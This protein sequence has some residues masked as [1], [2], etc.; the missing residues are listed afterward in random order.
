M[1]DPRQDIPLQ[2]AKLLPLALTADYAQLAIE[3]AKLVAMVEA[4]LVPPI[5]APAL[6][7]GDRAAIDA[8]VD[9]EVGK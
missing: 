9:A 6:D 5:D 1:T 7:P 4:E 8:A 2:I 3:S